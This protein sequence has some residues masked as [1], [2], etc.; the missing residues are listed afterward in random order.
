[1]PA[2]LV[3]EQHIELDATLPK[4]SN[5]TDYQYILLLVAEQSAIVC[6]FIGLT[7]IGKNGKGTDCLVIGAIRVL[8]ESYRR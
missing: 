6:G 4:T 2:I 1:V 5:G 3:A 7:R 8:W